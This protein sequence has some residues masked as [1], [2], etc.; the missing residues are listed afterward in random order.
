MNLRVE[1]FDLV[2]SYFTGRS[3]F[4]STTEDDSSRHTVTRGVLQGVVLS[5]TLFNIALIGLADELPEIIRASLYAVE[6]CI[7]ASGRIRVQLHARLQTV[8]N[9][10]ILYAKRYG[11]QLPH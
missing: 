2:R 8:G 5:P 11:P 6:I 9:I 7:W 1:S 3:I 4:V 10:I